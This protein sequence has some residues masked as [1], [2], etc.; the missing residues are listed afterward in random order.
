[1]VNLGTRSGSAKQ[2]AI[3]RTVLGGVVGSFV[4]FYEFSVYAALAT[5]LTVVFFPT[6]APATALLSTLAIFTVAFFARPLGG[7]VWGAVG[8]RIGRKRTCP[9]HDRRARSG[10]RPAVLPTPG[11]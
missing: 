6:A 11:S 7:F 5:T 3:W 8:D 4:E 10:L 9:A 2:R 1:M